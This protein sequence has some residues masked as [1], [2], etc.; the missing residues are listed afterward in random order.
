MIIAALVT[1]A[2][3]LIAWILAPVAP[4]RDGHPPMPQPD[5]AR[6]AEATSQP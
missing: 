6:L 5:P 2:V 3:L 1:F 4:I